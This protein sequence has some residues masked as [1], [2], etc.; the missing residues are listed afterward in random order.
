MDEKNINHYNGGY[1][2][3]HPCVID[4]RDKNSAIPSFIISYFFSPS[5]ETQNRIKAQFR[6]CS[7]NGT[8]S[9]ND[10]NHPRW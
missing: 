10:S 5:I 8:D 3:N 6:K 2:F 7:S 9:I 4:A 1:V